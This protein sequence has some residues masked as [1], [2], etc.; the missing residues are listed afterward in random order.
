MEKA[1]VEEAACRLG[2]EEKPL[3]RRIMKGTGIAVIV[4][5]VL[6]FIYWLINLNS[7]RDT[8]TYPNLRSPYI[9]RN[10]F[11]ALILLNVP[12]GVKYGAFSRLK[13]IK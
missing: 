4:L 5:A 13:L 3:L 6:L 8:N 12:E 1:E 11:L 7:P 10:R 9:P 2:V